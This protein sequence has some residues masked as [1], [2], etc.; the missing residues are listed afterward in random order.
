MK[1]REEI[2]LGVLGWYAM[3][4]FINLSTSFVFIAI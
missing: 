3:V 1:W 2:G 4:C